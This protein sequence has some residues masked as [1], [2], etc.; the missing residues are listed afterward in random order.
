MKKDMFM[1]YKNALSGEITTPLCADYKAAWRKCGD[2][3]EMLVRLVMKQQSLPY[4]FAHCYQNKGLSK[5]YILDEFGDFINGKYTGIDVDGVKG[6][7]KTELYVGHDEPIN[8][9]DDVLSVM[10]SNISTLEIPTCKAMKIYCACD[11]EIHIVCDGFNSITVMLFD[12]SKIFIDDADKESNVSVY[13]YSESA[14][15]EM[16]KFCFANVKVFPK[17]LRL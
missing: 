3:K 4:F 9:A 1:F 7:Y 13:K 6:E 16:G 5:G 10:W 12:N 11:S 14:K 15:V 17:E 2:D 8:V